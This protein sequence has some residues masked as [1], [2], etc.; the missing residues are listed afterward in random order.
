MDYTNI[1]YTQLS[2]DYNCI[3]SQRVAIQSGF[4]PT[5]AELYTSI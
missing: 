2:K 3:L 5:W 4:I 1:L